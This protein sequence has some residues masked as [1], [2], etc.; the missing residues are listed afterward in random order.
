MHP[1]KK[2]IVHAGGGDEGVGQIILVRS[3]HRL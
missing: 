3:F 2:I 1:I